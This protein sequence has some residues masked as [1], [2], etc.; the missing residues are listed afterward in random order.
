MTFFSTICLIAYVKSAI[1]YKPGLTQFSS[2]YDSRVVIY[3]T[4]T[5][6]MRFATGPNPIT[7]ISNIELYYTGFE[8]SDWLSSDVFNE[9]ER[10]LYDT[11]Q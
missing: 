3:E 11:I 1:T 7:K 5:F 6:S 10:S 4:K 8:S 9:S 2:H